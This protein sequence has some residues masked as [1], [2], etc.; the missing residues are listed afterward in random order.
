[1][2]GK[3]RQAGPGQASRRL[4]NLLVYLF[5]VDDDDRSFTLPH[6]EGL[7]FLAC[8]LA[9]GSGTTRI[10]I[11][12]PTILFLFLFLVIVLFIFF[13][14]SLFLPLPS[15]PLPCLLSHTHHFVLIF[16]PPSTPLGRQRPDPFLSAGRAFL[17]RRTCTWTRTWTRGRER[18]SERVSERRGCILSLRLVIVLVL[19]G[20]LSWRVLSERR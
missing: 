1:M 10:F 18:V 7:F 12:S 11:L 15:S 3:G 5:V 13:Y 2:E 8:C 16:F 19:V 6:F 4:F 9:L 17:S 14:G 20:V